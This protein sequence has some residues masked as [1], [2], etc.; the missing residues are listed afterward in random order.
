MADYQRVVEFLRD[1]RQTPIQGVTD[2]IAHAA[3]EYAELAVQA[4]ERLRKCSAFLQQGLRSEALH[5]A[6]DTPNLLDLVAALDL[7]DPQQWAD[8]CANN[9]LPV[10]PPLALDRAGQLNEAYAADQPLEHLMAQHRL[11]A[12]ARAPVGQRLAVMRQLSTLEPANTSWEKDIRIFE[13]ARIRELPTTF[14]NAVRDRDEAGIAGLMTELTQSTWYEPLPDDLVT[15]VTDAYARMQRATVEEELRK[16]V[17]QLR[18][19]YA[20]QSVKECQAIVQRWKNI[21]NGAGVTSVSHELTGEI[22]PVIAWIAEEERKEERLKRFRSSCRVFGEMMDRGTSDLELEAAYAKL[23]EFGDPIP[24]ELTAR[25]ADR[26]AERQQAMERTHKF[27]LAMVG[28]TVLVILAVAVGGFWFYARATAAR[29]WAEKIK[30]ANVAHDLPAARAAIEKLKLVAPQ[31]ATDPAVAAAMADT[32]T[33]EGQYSQAQANAQQLSGL[34]DRLEKAAAPVVGNGAASVAE[35]FRTAQAIDDG[36]AEGRAYGNLAWADP[37]NKLPAAETRLQ[38]VLAGLRA[39]ASG[40]VK[41]QL[42]GWAQEIDALPQTSPAAPATLAK[43]ADVGKKLR[44]VQDTAGLDDQI[45][46]TAA[47]LAQKVETIRGGMDTARG[48][49]A[50]LENVRLAALSADDLKRALEHFV[51]RFPKA[52]PAADFGVALTRTAVAKSFEAWRELAGPYAGHFAPLSQSVAQK[53]IDAL[54]AYVTANPESPMIPVAN[55]YIDY[56]KRAAEALAE[57]GTWQTAFA[58]LLGTPMMSELSYMDCSD[59]KVS[60][61]YYVLGDIKLKLPK[62]NGVVTPTFETLN[63]KDLTKRI[64]V[65]IDP[66]MKLLTE[67]PV[68]VPHAKFASEMADAIKLIDE[69]NWDTYGLDLTDKLIKNAE[70]DIV[71]KAILLQ[72]TLKANELVAGWAIGDVYATAEREL[73]RQKPEDILWIDAAKV[74]AGTKKALQATM[75]AVPPA[76]TVRQLLA[77]KKAELAKAM[78]PDVQGTGVLLK[79]SGGNWEIAARA[80]MREG[81]VAWVIVP[82]ATAGQPASLVRVGTV[83]G[84]KITLNETVL[85]GAVQGT[86]VYLTK[87]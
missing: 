31:L 9:G 43:L 5:S 22:K 56:L 10:P 33:L 39:K 7:P 1:L 82:S 38:T 71:V 30:T 32:Q 63:P 13:R 40:A 45:K 24:E 62:I 18:D 48:M 17:A 86:M 34:Y 26:R 3:K 65:S 47:A 54:N 8:F 11:L 81:N 64:T 19:A 67:K 37:E 2:E 70:I 66:P 12:L 51:Q 73:A 44:V 85:G 59:G 53:R 55:S 25:Y 14:L 87:P 77:A 78:A 68:L 35:L 75:D 27:R 46:S 21:M 15:A 57:K 41:A 69:S 83:G 16:L 79:D 29:S 61:R 4:N 36:L 28:A 42:E 60:T 84:G 80:G 74:G 52:D 6:D 49:S 58:D 50:E 23:A 72:Q 76:A 20:A